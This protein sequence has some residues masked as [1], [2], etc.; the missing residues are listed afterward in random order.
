[1][2][3]KVTEQAQALLGQATDMILAELEKRVRKTLAKNGRA[4]SFTMAMGSA[5]FFDKDNE[6]IDEGYP[7]P[8]WAEPVF[9]L[10]DEF[11]R[12]LYL[13]GVPMRIASANAPVERDW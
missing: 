12:N 2:S 8:K 10:I 4:K 7:Y 3:N 9:G 1:M 13:T 11:D 5:A 6:P